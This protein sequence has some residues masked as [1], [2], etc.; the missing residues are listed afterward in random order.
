VT[1]LCSTSPSIDLPT[2][3]GVISLHLRAHARRVGGHAERYAMNT[4]ET[5]AATSLI[6]IDP[7]QDVFDG[8]SEALLGYRLYAIGFDAALALAAVTSRTPF[9]PNEAAIAAVL[10]QTR[11]RIADTVADER[12]KWNLPR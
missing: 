7:A 9:N 2:I 1:H 12:S 8:R 11:F 3:D 6:L 4:S 5:A 10:G